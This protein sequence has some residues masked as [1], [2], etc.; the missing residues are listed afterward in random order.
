MKSKKKMEKDICLKIRISILEKQ[1]N[2]F[3]H[4]EVAAI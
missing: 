1:I 4:S 2:L 3:E